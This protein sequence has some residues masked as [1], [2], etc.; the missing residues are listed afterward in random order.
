MGALGGGAGSY[1]D[2]WAPGPNGAPPLLQHVGSDIQAGKDINKGQGY[3]HNMSNGNMQRDVLIFA[4]A[5][6]DHPFTFVG[7]ARLAPDP[8]NGTLFI[9]NDPNHVCHNG[10][11]PTCWLQM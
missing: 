9:R 2:A 11:S 7:I 5:L 1:G 3:Y 4:K 10:P 8:A 6:K